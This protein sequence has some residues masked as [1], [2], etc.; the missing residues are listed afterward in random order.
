MAE[1]NKQ[2]QT[3]RK[4]KAQILDEVVEKAHQQKQKKKKSTYHHEYKPYME[5]KIKRQTNK[6]KLLNPNK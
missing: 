3:A 4:T 1:N 5:I 6:N 2:N